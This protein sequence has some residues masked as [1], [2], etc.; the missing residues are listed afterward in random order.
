MKILI[1]LGIIL[2]IAATTNPKKEQHI[3]AVKSIVS[4]KLMSEYDGLSKGSDLEKAGGA[5]G[6]TLGMK[7]IETMLEGIISIDNYVVLSLTRATY[8]GK[9]KIIG[10][11]AIG[12][13]FLSA[14]INDGIFRE[15]DRVDF[16]GTEEQRFLDALDSSAVRTN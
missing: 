5:I 7:A 4:S 15:D 9:T 1:I 16:E 13:V 10:V 11:G 2:I 14:K 12:N 8:K 6:I 3:D